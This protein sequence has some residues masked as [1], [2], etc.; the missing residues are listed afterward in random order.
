MKNEYI[1]IPR[2]W[3]ETLVRRANNAS[4]EAERQIKKGNFEAVNFSPLIG[5]SQSAETLLKHL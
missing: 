3:L 2:A 5:H 4:D 1:T